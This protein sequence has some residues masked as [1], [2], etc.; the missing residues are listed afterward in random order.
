MRHELRAVGRVFVLVGRISRSLSPEPESETRDAVPERVGKY[1]ILRRIGAGGFGTVYLA[2]DESL[3]R[4]VALKI[5]SPSV[6]KD[7]RLRDRFIKEAQ[8]AA[9]MEHEGIVRVYAADRDGS[10]YYIASEYLDGR[11][12]KDDLDAGPFDLERAVRI[13][14]DLAQA[15]A[16]AHAAGVVHRDVKPA[17]VIITNAGDVKLIDFGLARL[18]SST[19]TSDCAKLG[20]P[21]YMSPEQAIGNNDEVGPTS[22]QYSL[23]VILYEMLCGR[24]PFAGDNRTVLYQVVHLPVPGPREHVTAIPVELEA[25]SLKALGEESLLALSELPRLRGGR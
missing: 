4:R 1:R 6:V 19:L 9:G 2:H 24:P 17:N 12:L 23:G 3:D 22:D 13:T 25:I 18:G 5:A 16:H 7:L 10:L 21:V 8:A 11:T 20:T 15:L 14:I